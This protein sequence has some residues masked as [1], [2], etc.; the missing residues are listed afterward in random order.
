M[1][2][3]LIL[4]FILSNLLA[5]NLPFDLYKKDSSEGDTLLVIGGIHGNEPGGYFSAAIL[6]T[7][8]KITKGNLWVVPNLNFESLLKNNRGIYGDMNRKFDKITKDDKDYEDVERI[9]KIILSK[10]VDFI[11]NL[12]DGRG[13]YREHWENSIFNPSA[14]GQAFIV[15]QK[16]LDINSKYKDLDIF[17]SK[18]QNEINKDL[19]KNHHIFNL[20]NTKTKEKDEQMQQSLTYFAITHGKPAI[21]IETSKNIEDLVQ[22]VKYQLIAIE[23]IMK[24]M[25]IKFQK[26]FDVSN[27]DVLN[28]IINNYMDVSIN[29]V[30][31]LN[32]ND[33]R[34]SLYYFPLK[35]DGNRFNFK[36]PLGSVIKQNDRYDLM[37]GNKRVTSITLNILNM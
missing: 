19:A 32:L 36:H 16:K 2:S 14:W 7:S 24:V 11:A 13:F 20:K 3:I 22:K 10:E 28:N 23:K 12:H 9:K 26:D 30:V 8:Y 21:A 25:G 1:K 27:Y 18:V 15:D 34:P 35:K 4:I 31:T 17:L 6:A 5:S 29:D 37:I 33:I